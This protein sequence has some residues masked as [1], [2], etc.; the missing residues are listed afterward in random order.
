VEPK[1]G[2]HFVHDI[3]GLNVVDEKGIGV[4]VVKD[5]LRLPAQDVYVIEKDG[6]EWMLPAVKEFVASIDVV[7]RTMR[8]RVIEGLME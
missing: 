6:R 1:K 5:V 2:T 7:A 4:G 8:V 3:V